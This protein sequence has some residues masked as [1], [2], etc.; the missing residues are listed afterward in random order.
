MGIIY[1]NDTHNEHV[2]GHNF[3]SGNTCT[4]NKESLVDVLD[5]INNQIT[6]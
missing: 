6:K 2:L 1:F 5:F 4:F 3:N